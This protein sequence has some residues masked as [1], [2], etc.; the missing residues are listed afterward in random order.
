[1]LKMK[2][3]AGKRKEWIV[4]TSRKVYF[5]LLPR[6]RRCFGKELLGNLRVGSTET[7]C[8]CV[9]TYS[10]PTALEKTRMSSRILS[11]TERTIC[12]P[13]VTPSNDSHGRV[14]GRICS[15]FLESSMMSAFHSFPRA[16]EPRLPSLGREAASG[17]K[18]PQTCLHGIFDSTLSRPFLSSTSQ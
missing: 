2:R 1:M 14:Y 9:S 7:T 4:R 11:E 10:R 15:N 12:E 6:K 18:N 8:T 3:T 13:I 17:Y 16:S 5:L